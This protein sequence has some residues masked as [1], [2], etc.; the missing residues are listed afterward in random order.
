VELRSIGRRFG[1]KG[2]AVSVWRLAFG[3][4]RLAFGVRRRR[5][6]VGG[7]RLAVGGW[8]LRSCA[9]WRLI[10]WGEAP[11]RPEPLIKEIEPIAARFA[12]KVEPRAE[13]GPRHGTHTGLELAG[14]RVIAERPCWKVGRR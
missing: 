11:E 8:R 4:R 6:A 10:W 3:V 12:C 14:D 2:L 1:L 9:V 5:L 7:W 13:P